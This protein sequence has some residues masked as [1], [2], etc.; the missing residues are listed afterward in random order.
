MLAFMHLNLIQ[1]TEAMNL[2][3]KSHWPDLHLHFLQGV[4][5]PMPAV[6]SDP[7]GALCVVTVAVKNAVKV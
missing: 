1:V 3:L 6:P 5:G 4:V 7:I 2:R